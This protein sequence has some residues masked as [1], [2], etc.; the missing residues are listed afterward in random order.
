[1]QMFPATPPRTP[2]EMLSSSFVDQPCTPG[3]TDSSILDACMSPCQI[4]TPRTKKANTDLWETSL[5]PTCPCIPSS[6]HPDDSDLKKISLPKDLEMAQGSLLSFLSFA[7]A[8]PPKP[9]LQRSAG[10]SPPRTPVR[11]HRR[12]A[13]KDVSPPPAPMKRRF[14]GSTFARAL[15]QNDLVAVVEILAEQP[16]LSAVPL[17]DYDGSSE[18]PITR[19]MRLGC[20]PE[21]IR[22][23]TDNGAS[24]PLSWPWPVM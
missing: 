9:S 5:T 20:D 19:A 15:D 12:K 7:A 13:Q 10:S 11:A 3:S 21:I 14:A 17:S 6:I 8:Q 2:L 18:F 4:S 23:L 1:M 22:V 24:M 16:S